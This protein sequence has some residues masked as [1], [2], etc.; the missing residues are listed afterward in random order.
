MRELVLQ[1]ANQMASNLDHSLPDDECPFVFFTDAR[2]SSAKTMVELQG[3]GFFFSHVLFIENG[4][5]SSHDLDETKF[6][7]T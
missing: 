5:P 6:G 4:T 3:M 7:E 1:L 2:F